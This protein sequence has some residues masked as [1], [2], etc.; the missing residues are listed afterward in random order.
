MLSREFYGSVAEGYPVD[1]ALAEARAAIKMRVSAVEWG[2]PV[3]F[4]RSRDGLLFA[5]ERD[6]TQVVQESQHPTVEPDR[7]EAGRGIPG[8]GGHRAGTKAEPKADGPT[9][10]GQD[11]TSEI[12]R[13]SNEAAKKQPSSMGPPTYGE[14]IL[15][16]GW[17]NRSLREMLY[18]HDFMPE[19]L[20]LTTASWNVACSFIAL[21]SVLLPWAKATVFTTTDSS[22]VR[23]H[24]RGLLF[25]HAWVV[26][27]LALVLLLGTRVLGVSAEGG[28]RSGFL[29]VLG[30]ILLGWLL[31]S[32]TE[33]LWS[34]H[35]TPANYPAI[36]RPA[37]TVGPQEVSTGYGYLMAQ[38]AGLGGFIGVLGAWI[39][40]WV[41]WRRL[42]RW[43]ALSI[44][45]MAIRLLR[46]SR[47]E[48]SDAERLALQMGREFIF[49]EMPMVV[50]LARLYLERGLLVLTNKRLLFLDG[51]NLV[52]HVREAIVGAELVN[53]SDLRIDESEGSGAEIHTTTY[54][55]IRPDYTAADFRRGL[56]P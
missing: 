5:M 27:A 56:R 39:C 51:T 20:L 35:L 13:E 6:A 45:P 18:S 55:E 22:A 14:A 24:A 53:D 32:A 31:L 49:E 46:I 41:G 44:Q 42:Y 33:L 30:A 26:G 4:M 47:H 12:S 1:S 11:R 29:A 28:S 50:A 17:F 40:N 34:R 52:A 7:E 9:A 10:T 54:K 23:V 25:P 21:V 15:A 38:L 16:R 2:V 48:G 8:H 36:A 43:G 19:W 3:L 37:G